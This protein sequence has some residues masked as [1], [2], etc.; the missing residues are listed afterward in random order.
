MTRIARMETDEKNVVRIVTLY[1]VDKHAPGRTQVLRN[2]I[3]EIAKIAGN[4][5]VKS[6]TEELK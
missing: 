3:T 4:N 6:P 2:L 1:V 5:E